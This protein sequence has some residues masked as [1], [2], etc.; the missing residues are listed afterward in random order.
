MTEFADIDFLIIGATKSATTWLQRALQADPSIAMP[1]PELH[2]FS[3]EFER[4]DDWYLGCFPE[5]VAGR[6]VGEKSN[7]YLEEPVAAQRIQAKLPEVKLVAQLRNPIER[8]YSD[9]CMMYRR[10]EVGRDVAFYLDPRNE[11]A[12]RLLPA[13]LYHRNLQAFYDRFPRDNIYVTVYEGIRIAPRQHL[14]GIRRFL[15]LPA[16]LEGQDLTTKAKDKTTPVLGPR[17]RRLLKPLKPAIAPYRTTTVFRRL[18]STIANEVRYP[19][20]PRETRARLIDYYA[21]DIAALGD[22]TRSDLVARWIAPQGS[23]VPAKAAV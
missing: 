10:G 11:H 1:D 13:G 9:Y 8:A 23:E 16:Q 21:G 22:L 5:A 20:M 14:E 2:Y 17:M 15:G 4:G 12:T 3:R 18:H 7:S 19:P 6:T